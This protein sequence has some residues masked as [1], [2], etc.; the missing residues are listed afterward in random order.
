MRDTPFGIA[1]ENTLSSWQ[2]NSPAA[3][4]VFSGTYDPRNICEVFNQGTE[5]QRERLFVCIEEERLCAKE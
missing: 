2:G 3:F 5:L 1:A 4:S